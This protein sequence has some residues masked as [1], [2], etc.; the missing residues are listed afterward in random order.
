M[1]LVIAF[2]LVY[3]KE[4]TRVTLKLML[5]GVILDVTVGQMLLLRAILFVD[6]L[7]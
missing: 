1:N 3:R 2:G 5:K 7:S 6:Y 4:L